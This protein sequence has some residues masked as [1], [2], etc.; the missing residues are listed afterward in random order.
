M[1]MRTWFCLLLALSVSTASAGTFPI[2]SFGPDSTADHAH[3]AQPDTVDLPVW[4]GIQCSPWVGGTR[5]TGGS[6][7]EFDASGTPWV[8]V[9]T[10][11]PWSSPHEAWLAF[12]YERWEYALHPE[13]ILFGNLVL[14]FISP[15]KV[16]QFMVRTGVDRLIGRDQPVGLALGGGLGLGY[17]VGRVGQLPG[18]EW[19]VPAELLAHAMTTVRLGA[20][21]RVSAGVI[22][23]PTFDLRNGG[24]AM[25]HWE[26]ELR[27]E[28]A[29]G[30]RG[31]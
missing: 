19:T 29:V 24:D 1:P 23:G 12:G 25:M 21:T 9:S 28:R 17:A 20:R 4:V 2:T 15:V 5:S 22:G 26:L 8:G 13:T 18:S 11:W 3:D 7:V 16:E 6:D 31:P 30:R 10:T 14:P 27:L